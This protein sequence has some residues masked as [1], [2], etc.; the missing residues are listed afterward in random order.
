VCLHARGLKVVTREG[1]QLMN[2]RRLIS[3]LICI[4]LP[5][6]SSNAQS[7]EIIIGTWIENR[8]PV[9]G[10]IVIFE[11]DEGTFLRSTYMDGSSSTVEQDVSSVRGGTKYET[12]GGNSFGEYFIINS[13]DELEY[14]SEA[15]KFYTAK[16]TDS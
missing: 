6:F 11:T 14:W 5:L 2:S 16:K 8:P 4:A 12:K 3:I 7:E 13:D 1:I 10:E 15:D 9:S